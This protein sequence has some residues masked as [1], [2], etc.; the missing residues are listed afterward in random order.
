MEISELI[1]IVLRDDQRA[2]HNTKPVT[3]NAQ[4]VTRNP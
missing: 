1:G 2:T 3:R 4:L